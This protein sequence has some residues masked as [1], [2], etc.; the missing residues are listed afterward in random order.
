MH[1][2]I[3]Q[4]PKENVILATDDDREGEA[5]SW[6]I[7]DVFQLPIETTKRIVF[8]EITKSAIV[9]ALENPKTID[10]KLVHAQHARQVPIQLLD[11]IYHPCC[12]NLHIITKVML[13]LLDVVKHLLYD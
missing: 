6:H 13:F 9:N 11:S 12:G 3:K 2:A 1:Y 4:Y 5:I 7:C 8:N 10:M